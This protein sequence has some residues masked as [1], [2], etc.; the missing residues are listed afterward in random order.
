MTAQIELRDL[1]ESDLPIFYR[2]QLDPDAVKMVP[3]ISRSKDAFMTH[4]HKIIRDN[5][6]SGK[7]VL[8]DGQVAGNILCFLQGDELDIGYW[9]GREFWGKGI[10]SKALAQFLQVV[11]QRPLHAYVSKQNPGSLRV[12]QKCGFVITGE[13]TSFSEEMNQEIQEFI[14]TLA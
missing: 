11:P 13:E 6:I 12:L 14:L 1:L 5:A 7:T 9:Y 3:F 10:A 4:W 2:H 8:Y